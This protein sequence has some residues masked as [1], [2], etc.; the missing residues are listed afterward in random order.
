MGVRPGQGGIAD[1]VRVDVG[2][3]VD[4]VHDLVHVDA[5]VVRHHP[6]VAV[7]AGIQQ[8]L[9]LLVLFRVQHVVAL[10]QNKRGLIIIGIGSTRRARSD[11]D[12]SRFCLF[13]SGLNCKT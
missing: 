1:D 5:G 2:E 10:L 13:I 11:L 4:L 3:F 12:E 7:A 6:V 9:V 8:P